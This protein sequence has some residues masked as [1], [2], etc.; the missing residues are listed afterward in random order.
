MLMK[1][2]YEH[3]VAQEA[4][5]AAKVLVNKAYTSP[6]HSHRTK[7]KKVNKDF[8]LTEHKQS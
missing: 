3:Q 1:Q 7:D 4:H 2:Q 5:M 8:R 6:E